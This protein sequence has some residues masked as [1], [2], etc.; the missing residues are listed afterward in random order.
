MRTAAPPS[1]AS[2]AAGL[3]FYGLLL[4]SLRWVPVSRCG[5]GPAQADRF[6]LVA[7]SVVLVSAV[8]PRGLVQLRAG[9]PGALAPACAQAAAGT[10]AAARLSLAPGGG[11]VAAVLLGFVA[12]GGAL[13]PIRSWFSRR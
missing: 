2:K 6:F 5:A 10:A 12:L 1:I 3:F 9:R 7:F 8:A 13:L 11:P 4:L